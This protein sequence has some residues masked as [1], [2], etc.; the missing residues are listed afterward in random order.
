MEKEKSSKTKPTVLHKVKNLF[1]SLDA[2]GEEYKF[3]V[4][5]NEQFKTKEGAV[6]T[7]IF[8]ILFGFSAYAA[9]SQLMDTTNPD[10]SVT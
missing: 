4:D 8:L 3:N 9:I 2:F 10:V 6:V 7:I 5:G 1:L